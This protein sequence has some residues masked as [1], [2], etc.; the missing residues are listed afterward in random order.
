MSNLSPTPS[1]AP[2]TDAPLTCSVGQEQQQAVRLH[3]RLGQEQGTHAGHSVSQLLLTQD[4]SQFLSII[5]LK[6]L[7]A[8]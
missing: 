8:T 2:K 5:L 7:L 6:F 4:L 1:L 3:F